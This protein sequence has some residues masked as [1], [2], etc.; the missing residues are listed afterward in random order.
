MGANKYAYRIFNI[1]FGIVLVFVY[2]FM[3]YY[4]IPEFVEEKKRAMAS[5]YTGYACTALLALLGLGSMM[6]DHL[7]E[8]A[9]LKTPRHK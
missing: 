9:A 1:A 3:D 2:L 6:A 5:A 4:I 8:T 7:D